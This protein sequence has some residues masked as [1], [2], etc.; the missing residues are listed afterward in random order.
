MQWKRLM[1][2]F[3]QRPL[4]RWFMRWGIRFTAPRHLVGVGLV[5]LDAQQRVFLLRHV[6]HPAHPWGVPGGWLQRGE[7]PAAG[8][9]RELREETGL[10]AVIDDI[11]EVN[12]DSLSD[13]VEIVYI[14]TLQ[15][16]TPTLNHEILEARWFALN[17]LPP[18]LHNNTRQLIK[19]AARQ[20]VLETTKEKKERKNG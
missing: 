7:A 8:A 17:E 16:G 5:L 15:P 12:Y 14:A 20:L 2:R 18:G 10:T 1:A 19:K 6:F 4:P 11:L 3:M 13:A 9:L